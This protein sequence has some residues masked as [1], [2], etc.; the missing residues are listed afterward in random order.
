[1]T[2]LACPHAGAARSP[3]GATVVPLALAGL[4]APALSPASARAP[5]ARGA[6]GTG[7]APGAPGAPST[8]TTGAKQGIG[9]ATTTRLEGVVQPRR[10]AR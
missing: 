7:A 9:T 4:A 5:R 8:W 1:M 3:V 6:A 10:R 2:R